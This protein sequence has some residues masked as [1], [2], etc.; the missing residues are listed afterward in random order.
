MVGSKGNFSALQQIGTA[1]GGA[2]Y[3]VANS[4]DVDKVFLAAVSRRICQG[5][6]CAG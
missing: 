5:N 2:A 6:S 3:E 4:S 1:G